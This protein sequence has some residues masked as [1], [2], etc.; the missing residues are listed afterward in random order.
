MTRWH[1]WIAVETRICVMECRDRYGIVWRPRMS[2]KCTSGKRWTYNIDAA[3]NKLATIIR[4]LNS[5][6]ELLTRYRTS[7]HL[8]TGSYVNVVEHTRIVER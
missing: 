1:H 7:W 4:I 8:A 6:E 3:I 2:L 5:G